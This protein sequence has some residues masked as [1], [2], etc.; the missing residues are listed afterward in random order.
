MGGYLVWHKLGFW[1]AYFRWVLGLGF[2]DLVLVVLGCFLFP[3]WVMLIWCF[4]FG[5]VGV[6]VFD[7]LVNLHIWVYCKD[8]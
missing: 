6:L 1:V 4:W 8:S 2:W 5:D 7:V 3:C